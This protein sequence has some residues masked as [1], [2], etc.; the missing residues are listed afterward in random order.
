MEAILYLSIAMLLLA[1]GYRIGKPEEVPKWGQLH[2][3]QKQAYLRYAEG[4]GN[5][6]DIAKALHESKRNKI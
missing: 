4:L 1:I 6:I 5:Y 2:D 3:S